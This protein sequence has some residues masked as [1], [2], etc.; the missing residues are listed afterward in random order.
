M[1]F[2]FRY[3]HKNFVNANKPYKVFT[4]IEI[5]NQNNFFS[6]LTLSKAI[7]KSGKKHWHWKSATLLCDYCKTF[8]YFIL[9]VR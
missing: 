3:S 6:T 1:L 5:Y 9:T 4:H 8:V 7:N 2:V